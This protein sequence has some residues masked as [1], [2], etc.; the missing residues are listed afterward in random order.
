MNRRLMQRNAW[1]VTVRLAYECADFP[2]L[3]FA[4][5]GDEVASED[6]GGEQRGP[7]DLD[8][9][10]GGQRWWPRGGAAIA[11]RVFRSEEPAMMFG[12]AKGVSRTSNSG[13]TAWLSENGIASAD[14]SGSI[15]PAERGYREG[16]MNA[17]G[18]I[19]P[20]QRGLRGALR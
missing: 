18:R 11:E 5:S 6:L 14:G 4:S 12:L 19:I 3:V 17:T 15:Q 16:M 1:K 9:G 8:F 20:V 7:A 13:E 2:N 10:L